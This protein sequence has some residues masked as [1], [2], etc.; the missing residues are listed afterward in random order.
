VRALIAGTDQLAGDLRPSE[1]FPFGPPDLRRPR[2]G[3][4]PGAS[5]NPAPWTPS[6]PTCTCRTRQVVTLRGRALC[7][8]DLT[9]RRQDRTDLRRE[10]ANSGHAVGNSSR[11]CLRRSISD[12]RPRNG[13]V[14]PVC[15]GR[16]LTTADG[17]TEASGESGG[18][19][20]ETR[21]RAG[22]TR[23]AT[24]VVVRVFSVFAA[25]RAFVVRLPVGIP[26]GDPP[27]NADPAEHLHRKT[28]V[29][30][31]VAPSPHSQKLSRVG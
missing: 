14:E 28:K 24:I 31:H 8:W 6:L 20:A 29:T 21:S 1:S 30:H 12:P 11:C 27:M 17:A 7:P 10:S 2:L 5:P 23:R 15:A 13:P 22:T 9:G 25:T 18:R 4:Y 3:R 19:R 26:Q 16:A